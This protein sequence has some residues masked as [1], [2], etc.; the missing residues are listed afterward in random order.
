[1]DIKLVSKENEP[2]AYLISNLVMAKGVTTPLTPSPERPS[3]SPSDV[4]IPS[5]S[6]GSIIEFGNMEFPDIVAL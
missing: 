3:P 1:M 2:R 4:E 6:Q 5:V